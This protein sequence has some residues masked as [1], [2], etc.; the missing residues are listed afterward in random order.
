MI[1][2]INQVHHHLE[3][4]YDI[5]LYLSKGQVEI[6]STI[7]IIEIQSKYKSYKFSVFVTYMNFC[8]ISTLL[9]LLLFGS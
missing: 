7:N 8:T 9:L 5:S 3:S 6:L 4:A 2:I 1:K